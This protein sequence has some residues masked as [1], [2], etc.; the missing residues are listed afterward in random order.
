[1]ACLWAS[2]LKG[3]GV[4]AL[5]SSVVHLTMRFNEQE[6]S[7]GTGFLYERDGQMYIITAWHNVTG[8]N[9]ESLELLSRRG[10]TPNNVLATLAL[11]TSTGM[12][13]RV[14]I[15]VQLLDDE[16]SLYFI[17]P[18]SYPKVDVVAIP[19]D[20]SV[21]HRMGMMLEAHDRLRSGPLCQV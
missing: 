7:I 9:A 17:H 3:D 8:R 12:A 2:Q 21:P 14:S 20:T 5:N 10:A 18:H 19:L 16:K 15:E 4:A 11:C 6:L 1:M 13:L